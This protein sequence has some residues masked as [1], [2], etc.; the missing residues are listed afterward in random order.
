VYKRQQLALRILSYF[1]DAKYVLIPLLTKDLGQ[2]A[3]RPLQGG[4]KTA[5]FLELY[6]DFVFST[7]D[8]YVSVKAG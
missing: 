6:P 1:P 4:L 5:K 7:V 2:P 3:A 8:E